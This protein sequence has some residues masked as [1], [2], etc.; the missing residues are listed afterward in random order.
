MIIVFNTIL[1]KTLLMGESESLKDA[2]FAIL[3]PISL[4]TS[5]KKTLGIDFGVSVLSVQREIEHMVK[6]QLW[7]LHSGSRFANII[8]SFLKGASGCVIVIDVNQR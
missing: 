4:S 8:P 3:S 7:V 5:S 6:L 2:L 1:F